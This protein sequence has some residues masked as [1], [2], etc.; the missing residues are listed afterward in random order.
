MIDA[1][2][3]PAKCFVARVPNYEC[4]SRGAVLQAPRSWVWIDVAWRRRLDLRG[5]SK[6]VMTIH[7][8]V[9]MGAL[10]RYNQKNTG[11]K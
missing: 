8:S 11:W 2:T 1:S 9:Y 5:F 10:L 6:V 4:R 3:L 7:I